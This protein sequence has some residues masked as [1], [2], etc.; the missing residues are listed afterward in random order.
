MKYFI[1]G[2]FLLAFCTLSGCQAPKNTPTPSAFETAKV[3][4]KSE[5]L[6]ITQVSPHAYEHTTFLM[7]ETWGKVPCNG[8]IVVN[9]GEALIFDTPSDEKSSE[10]LIQWVKQNLKTEIK[11]IIPTH[12]HGDAMGSLAVF[13]QHK[14]SSYANRQ[15]IALAKAQN[16]TIPQ[17]GFEGTLTL[18]LG[19]KNVQAAFLGEGHTKDNIVGYF[20]DEGV[21]FGGCLIKELDAGKGYLGDANLATWSKTVETVKQ[22]YPKAKIV[23]PGHGERGDQALLDYTIRLFKPQE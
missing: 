4:Y 16:L 17:H 7:T 9:Q 22:T 14:I 2:Y 23:I 11:G 13:H 21:L 3:L 6:I 10:E 20:P 1:L 19:N 18:K 12:F 5:L 15:T 8:M